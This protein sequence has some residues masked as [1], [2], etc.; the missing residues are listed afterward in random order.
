MGYVRQGTYSLLGHDVDSALNNVGFVSLHVGNTVHHQAANAVRTLI[1]SHQVSSLCKS[2]MRL[3]FAAFTSFRRVRDCLAR[4]D[5]LIE[6]K[7]EAT[8][9]KI[10]TS[11]M[12]QCP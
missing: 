9:I 10:Q 2:N 3:D 8:P 11:V 4:A 5:M 12:L 7:Y 1:H 6:Y